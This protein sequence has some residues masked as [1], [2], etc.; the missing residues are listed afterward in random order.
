[1]SEGASSARPRI[2]IAMPSAVNA[3][4]FASEFECDP[5]FVAGVVFTT[6]A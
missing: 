6:N 3:F 5:G 2:R 1:M 4:L